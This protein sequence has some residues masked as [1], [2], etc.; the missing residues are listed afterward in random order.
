MRLPMFFKKTR[1]ALGQIFHRPRISINRD[2]L[3]LASA[4]LMVFIVAVLIRM[5]PF[6]HDEALMRAFDPWFQW[7]AVQY[8]EENGLLSKLYRSSAIDKENELELLMNR[9]AD[10]NEVDPKKL[11]TALQHAVENDDLELNENDG[12]VGWKW[13]SFLPPQKRQYN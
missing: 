10:S 8:I 4:L 12:K 6:F 2:S 1:K 11:K 13:R 3:F 9:I 5:L 7:R